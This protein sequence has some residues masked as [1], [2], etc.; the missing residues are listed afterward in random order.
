MHVMAP[1]L[2][3]RRFI[4]ITAAA[5]GLSLLPCGWSGAAEANVVTW[6][7]QA[8]GAPATL[9]IHHHDRATAER[10]AERTAVEV[11]RLERVFSLYRDDSALAELNRIGALAAPPSDLFDLLGLCATF[12]ASTGGVF[13]PTVQPLWML[14]ARHFQAPGADPAGP[15]ADRLR[16]TVAGVGFDKV[17]VSR[18]RIAFSRPDM[19]LTLN[20]IAQGYITDSIVD[21]L[22]RGGIASSLVD[23]G[24]IRAIGARPDGAPWTV[25]VAGSPATPI[26]PDRLEIV[27]KAVASSSP[28]G[29]HFDAAGY[30]NHLLD[31]RTGLPSRRWRGVT[32]VASDA[33]TADALSTAFSLMEAGPIADVK[34]LHG[35]ARIRLTDAERTFT[36]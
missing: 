36:L 12:R 27:D 7:G 19:A 15:A 11:A 35:L 18:N 14:Y 6:H 1:P 33:A 23:M 5:A 24:E 31:P 20:G 17:E 34:R 29:F 2:T 4:G 25:G 28:D 8:L 9:L 16:D 13:D 21:L 32:V 26:A 30:F 10:L 22:R 3:R